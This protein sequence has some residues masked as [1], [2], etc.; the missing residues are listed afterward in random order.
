M[1]NLILSVVALNSPL[2]VVDLFLF[3][4]PP[5]RLLRSLVIPILLLLE[6]HREM[7]IMI[8]TIWSF[9]SSCFASAVDLVLLKHSAYLL[10]CLI[11]RGEKVCVDEAEAEIQ[12]NGIQYYQAQV[13][14]ETR[15]SYYLL[16]C[17]KLQAWHCTPLPSSLY[18]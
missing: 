6:A 15:I 13:K 7:A 18:C 11:K 5:L 9:S 2:V 17:E 16:I 14:Q 4:S 3:L 10:H 1:S 12:I 8:C